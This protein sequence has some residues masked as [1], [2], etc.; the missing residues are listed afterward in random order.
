MTLSQARPSNDAD[1]DSTAGAGKESFSLFGQLSPFKYFK[2]CWAFP[3]LFLLFHA[4]GGQCGEKGPALC[5]TECTVTYGSRFASTIRFWRK[6]YIKLFQHS[7]DLLL[8]SL[9]NPISVMGHTGNVIS[10]TV[11]QWNLD[12]ILY[13]MKYCFQT[14][15][16]ILCLSTSKLNN[17]CTTSVFIPFQPLKK[18]KKTNTLGKNNFCKKKLVNLS[19]RN[20][21]QNGRHF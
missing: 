17:R 11:G 4:Q 1:L 19:N 3:L 12:K 15:A 7:E 10:V 9:S 20:K 21:W 8:A 2:H 5:I 14:I 16:Q 18:K 6:S 13:K